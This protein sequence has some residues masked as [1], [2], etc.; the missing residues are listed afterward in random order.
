MDFE[1]AGT[2]RDREVPVA[3]RIGP[4]EGL[5]V[6]TQDIR[7]AVRG[8]ETAVL[9]ALGID[10]RSGRPHITCPYPEHG[11]TNDWRWDAP[12][13]RARCTCTRGDSIFDVV[14]KMERL[15][16]ERAKRRV[17]EL[18]GRHD[19]IKVKGGQRHPRTDAESL[20]RPPA[21][22][23]DDG[24]V[25][26]YLAYRLGIASD[27]VRTPATPTA[28]WRALP[29]WDPPAGDRG[30]PKLVG[31]YPCAVFGTFAPDRRRHA[32]RIYVGPA[33]AG[34]ADLG[35]GPNGRPRDPKKSARK[36]SP[37][38]NTSGCA[39]IWGDRERAPWTIVTEGIE[40]AAAVAFAFRDQVGAGELVVAAA[41]FAVGV[42]AFQPWPATRRLMVAADR[43][44][45][46]KA[47]D[48]PGSRR[49]EDAA[50]ALGMRLHDQVAVDIALPG[51]AGESIDW[52]D[53]LRR[54][55]VDAVRAG[56]AAAVR[57]NPTDEE[58]DAAQQRA[59]RQ[60]RLD[61]IAAAYPLPIMETVELGYGHAPSGKV[62]VHQLVADRRGNETWRPVATPFGV[63]ARLRYAN[64]ADAFGLRV[65][66]QGM[67]GQPRDLDF[68][69]AALARMAASEIRSQL[70]AAGLRIE[71][72]GEAVAVQVL[73]AADPSAEI[74]VV[75]R[76]GW[77]QVADLASPVFVTPAGEVVGA[78]PGRALELAAGAR[79]DRPVSGTLVGWQRAIAAATPT[80]LGC[81]H[82]IIGAAAAFAGVVLEIAGL[83]SC[84]INLSGLSSSGKSLAQRL[85]VSA[86]SS[87]ALGRGLFKS[88]RTTENAA[89]SLAQA[90]SG[91]ILALDEMAHIDGR[92]LGRLIYSLAGGQGKARLTSDAALR[93]SYRWSTFA[94]LSGES[95]LEEK[96][97]ADRGQWL[98]GMAVRFPDVDVTSVNRAVPRDTLQAIEDG[99]ASHHGHAG[100]AFVRGLVEHGYHA[101]PEDLRQAVLDAARK[102]AGPD[103]DAA[104]VRAA[105]PFGL[106]LA[107]GGLAS[108]FGLLPDGVDA[109]GAVTW[110]WQAFHGSSDAVAL[111]PEE[112][113]VRN[114][115]TWIAER[116]DV[117]IRST[118]PVFD[119]SG[120]AR[121]E[122]REALG[123]YDHDAVYLPTGRIREAAG[124]TLK[125]V[126]IA[127]ILDREG[128]LAKRESDLRKSRSA[129]CPRLATCAAT[130]SAARSSAVAAARRTPGSR[131][132]RETCFDHQARPLGARARDGRCARR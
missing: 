79:L 132:T 119:F 92:T 17:A 88:L 29:Y 9:D 5:Y 109:G 43:D 83:D 14:L 20:L 114:L 57:F 37:E 6:T 130:R 23:R 124:G 51:S 49:G 44:E 1:P 112:L 106:L 78:P 36:T 121:K 76:P 115:R 4:A 35:L 15:D 110:A 107:A 13:A 46:P 18:L 123:W 129:T 50:R 72:D 39:V 89:E 22:Q 125:E 128:L 77:H 8:L 25:H 21:D 85:A 84:G 31:C 16:F 63:P 67:D 96:V 73:K 32:H 71:G 87:P 48:R 81:P 111:R 120:Q 66:V 91:T 45:E 55:G 126:Q 47:D 7:D 56:I 86:W 69:R 65:V 58:V 98:A 90:A 99:I 64:Q 10:W 80:E 102:L 59:Q 103:A 28:G 82:W 34:K 122:S 93:P 11:G 30:K 24:L 54:D 116:W 127:R 94:L 60:G 131:F 53:V 101:R 41:I 95:S 3:I 113:L 52:L 70:F 108:A 118:A 117:T 62:L 26:A 2:C 27:Q 97:R 12:A 40:T 104:R 75:S 33:G 100:P 74:T 42:E 38:Q 68:E 61:E 105:L 19:L